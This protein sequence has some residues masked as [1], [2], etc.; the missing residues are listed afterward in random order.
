VQFRS[1]LL[2]TAASALALSTIACS[3]LTRP[4]DITISAEPIAAQRVV[5]AA[6]AA[7]APAAPARGAGGRPAPTPASGG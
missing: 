4:D 6:A 3:A 1:L 2:F 7:P 5:P